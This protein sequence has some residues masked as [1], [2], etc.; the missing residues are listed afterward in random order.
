MFILDVELN[1]IIKSLDN[2]ITTQQ[3]LPDVIKNTPRGVDIHAFSNL[4]NDQNREKNNVESIIQKLDQIE[5]KVRQVKENYNLQLEVYKQNI[6][7]LN[8]SKLSYG[9]QGLIKNKYKTKQLKL[10]ENLNIYQEEALS[11][12][13]NKTSMPLSEKGGR[14]KRKT[15]KKNRK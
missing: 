8:N 1:N 13:M 3:K 11:L 10:P 2:I 12:P 14:K 4:V 7:D 5:T 9:L 15:R 6:M